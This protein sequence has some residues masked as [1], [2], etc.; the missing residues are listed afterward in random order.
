MAYIVWVAL[1]LESPKRSKF[2]RKLSKGFDISLT[3]AWR[4]W[5]RIGPVDATVKLQVHNELMQF[6][7][8]WLNM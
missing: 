6:L 3:I 2:V 8:L 5:I 1:N 7:K 4:L